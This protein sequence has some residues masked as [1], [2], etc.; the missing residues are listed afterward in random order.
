LVEPRNARNL[1][2]KSL[3]LL[4]VRFPVLR[5]KCCLQKMDI[6]WRS[7][8]MTDVTELHLGDAHVENLSVEQYWINIFNWR[9][10]VTKS[11]I[12]N[13]RSAYH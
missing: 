13:C 12:Q 8:A 10:A 1:K 4:F 5:E 7:Q 6:E 9:L 11:S 3:R 2:P